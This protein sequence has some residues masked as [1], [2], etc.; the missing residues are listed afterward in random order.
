MAFSDLV[1]ILCAG[2]LALI[3][4]SLP[5]LIVKCN[6]NGIKVIGGQR[7]QQASYQ[8]PKRSHSSYYGYSSVQKNVTGSYC[9]HYCGPQRLFGAFSIVLL[10]SLT[11]DL[12]PTILAH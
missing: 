5:T 11:L 2:G 6:L 8:R 1:S 9:P 4:T 7:S 3:F 12:K 10:V